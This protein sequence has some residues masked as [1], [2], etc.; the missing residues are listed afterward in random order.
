MTK[1]K[2]NSLAESDE[3]TVEM[4]PLFYGRQCNCQ[5]LFLWDRS[6][7]GSPKGRNEPLGV[8]GKVNLHPHDVKKCLTF[9]PLGKRRVFEQPRK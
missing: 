7:N 8:G 1:A 9:A 6:V 3:E 5:R 4:I 2:A